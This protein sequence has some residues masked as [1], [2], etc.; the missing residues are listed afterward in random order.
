MLEA[1]EER[2]LFWNLEDRLLVLK[3]ILFQLIDPV[4]QLPR[5]S[6]DVAPPERHRQRVHPGVT[7]GHVTP[8]HRVRRLSLSQG[9]R[10]DELPYLAATELAVDRKKL[11]DDSMR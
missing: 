9:V 5:R 6:V 11:N 3:Q 1:N 2:S 8:D 4:I 7:A 10:V